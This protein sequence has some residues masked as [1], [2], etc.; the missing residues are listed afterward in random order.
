MPSK[1]NKNGPT[2]PQ[3]SLNN[4]YSETQ[5]S[6]ITF[7]EVMRPTGTEKSTNPPKIAV[8]GVADFDDSETPSAETSRLSKDSRQNYSRISST[9]KGKE[10]VSSY[11]ESS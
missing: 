8:N 9:E 1:E 4:N 3:S 10:S 11:P 6:D 2:T 7:T 5:A